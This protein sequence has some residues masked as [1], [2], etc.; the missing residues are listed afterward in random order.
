M[1]ATG[2]LS[3]TPPAETARARRATLRLFLVSAAALFTEVMLIRWI[4]TEVRLFAFVQNLALIACFLGFGLG[5]FR[6]RERT[7]L[8]PSLQALAILVV[9]VSVPIPIWHL[10]LLSLSDMLALSP[11]A[12]IWNAY[13]PVTLP[14]ADRLVGL[15][16]AVVIVTFLIMLLR[17]AMIPFGQFVAHYLEES[18]NT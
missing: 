1:E 6:S 17:T 8:L 10:I 9:M 7:S 11:D 4:G 18:P 14:L 15:F 2:T 3:S 12:V 13:I 5:C 16:F